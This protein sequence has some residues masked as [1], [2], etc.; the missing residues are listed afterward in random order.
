MNSSTQ[1]GWIGIIVDCRCRMG[2]GGP[3]YKRPCKTRY[4]LANICGATRNDPQR[5]GHVGSYI[6]GIGAPTGNRALAQ[7]LSLCPPSLSWRSHSFPLFT[8]SMRTPHIYASRVPWKHAKLDKRRHI[9]FH[10]NRLPRSTHS[11]SGSLSTF[12]WLH[13]FCVYSAHSTMNIGKMVIATIYRRSPTE[14]LVGLLSSICSAT[15][16][17]C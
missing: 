11:P 10:Y 2:G 5:H 3:P 4:S 14:S 6:I 12:S 9:C 17:D 8:M 1:L 7:A 13:T 15:A 16:S